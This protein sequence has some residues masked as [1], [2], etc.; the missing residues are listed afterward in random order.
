MTKEKDL[1]YLLF[2]VSRGHHNLANRI[3]QEIGLYRGQPPVLFELGKHD[4]ITQSEL[5][6]TIEVT[7]ATLTNILNRMEASGLV[8]RQ[9]D[10]EDA[11]CSRIHLTEEGR[12]KLKQAIHQ[13]LVKEEI[14]FE[15]FTQE[16][17]VQLNDYFKRIH[18]N[19]TR[20]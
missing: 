11:R 20:E 6:E 19:L 7:Q 9:R 12:E 5:A 16:E 10:S 14:A 18:T 13:T 1:G 15:G 4:G 2:L 17:K 8:T 3:F